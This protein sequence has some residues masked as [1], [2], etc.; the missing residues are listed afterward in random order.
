MNPV[1]FSPSRDPW[2]DDSP[3]GPGR[4]PHDAVLLSRLKDRIQRRPAM[5]WGLLLVTLISMLF[6]G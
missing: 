3:G 1:L 5:E 4:T 6:P 2:M